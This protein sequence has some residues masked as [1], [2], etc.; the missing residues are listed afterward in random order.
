MSNG[1]F[2]V[3][4]AVQPPHSLYD[5]KPG[6]TSDPGPRP[7]KKLK[8]EKVKK[9]GV[10]PKTVTPPGSVFGALQGRPVLPAPTA[11]RV[12]VV[13][14]RGE[15]AV[16]LASETWP[17]VR[18]GAPRP[19]DT[20]ACSRSVS[21]AGGWRHTS[22][23][24]SG[25]RCSARKRGCGT[26]GWRPPAGLCVGRIRYSASRASG[27][28]SR[29]ARRSRWT[30]SESQCGGTNSPALREHQEGPRVHAGGGEWRGALC[31]VAARPPRQRGPLT[32]GRLLLPEGSGVEE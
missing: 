8:P 2:Q 3:L 17:R 26:C 1:T 15:L 19:A 30:R 12:R 21:A 23:R 31:A 28:E 4:P 24:G 29:R 10:Q 16:G 18:R 5:A 25:S 32:A 14:V 22:P 20:P 6:N 27:R 13:G 7:T 9:G 11:G